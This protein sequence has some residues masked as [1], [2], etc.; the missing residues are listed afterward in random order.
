MNVACA[1]RWNPVGGV[2]VVADPC[3]ERSSNTFGGSRVLN[4]RVTWAAQLGGRAPSF[5]VACRASACGP[6]SLAERQAFALRFFTFS[7]SCPWPGEAP[8]YTATDR[9]V[10]RALGFDAPP[11]PPAQTRPRPRPRPAREKQKQHL[12]GPTA[13]WGPTP[14]ATRHDTRDVCSRVLSGDW[15]STH[16]TMTRHRPRLPARLPRG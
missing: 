8:S 15:P 5:R 2:C 13:Y 11:P 3:F 4:V 10:F 12:R 1:R 9:T 7:L 6:R 16:A 14:G